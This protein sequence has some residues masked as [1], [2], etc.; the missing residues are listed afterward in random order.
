MNVFITVDVEI[1]LGGWQNLDERFPDSFKTYIYGP[2]PSGN[3]GL[4]LKLEI[5]NDH[6]LK[7][8]F[9][10]EPLFATR[11]GHEPLAEIV[12]LIRDAGQEVQMHL[13]TEWAD[14]AHE[15]LFPDQSGK[16]QCLYMYSQLEQAQLI[17]RAKSLLAE[18]GAPEINAFRAGSFSMNRETMSALAENGITYDSSYNHT[19]LSP[20]NNMANGQILVQPTQV[21][22]VYEYPMTVYEDRAGHYRHLQLGACSFSEIEDVFHQASDDGWNSMVLLSHNFELMNQRKTGPDAIV[23][24][25]FRKLARFLEKHADEFTTADF[26]TLN[27]E[28]VDRQPTPPRV[29]TSAVMIRH[30]EQLWRKLYR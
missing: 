25:R 2:T 4:P 9:F 3:C 14:E 24:G 20:K 12:G 28:I 22:G 23:L 19:Q 29:P 13:H 1:W 17:A 10:V 18:C 30:G 11:F 6:G 26:H 5:L 27:P 21:D 8:V 7:G 16:R 15:P